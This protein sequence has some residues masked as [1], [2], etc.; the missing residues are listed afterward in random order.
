MIALR[1]T[2]TN[3]SDLMARLEVTG[4]SGDDGKPSYVQANLATGEYYNASVSTSRWP[5]YPTT[6]LE[7]SATTSLRRFRSTQQAPTPLAN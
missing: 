4:T 7:R 3:L 2:G 5:P 1:V 6:A